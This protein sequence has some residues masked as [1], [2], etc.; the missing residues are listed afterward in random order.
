[1][2]G[3][4]S[5]E[6]PEVNRTPTGSP[7]LD[8]MSKRIG[9]GNTALSRKEALVSHLLPPAAHPARQLF[10][11]T[12]LVAVTLGERPVPVDIWRMRRDALAFFAGCPA[13]RRIAYIRLNAS[14]DELELVTFGRRGGWKREWR[15]GPAGR[16]VR[17]A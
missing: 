7:S 13:A 12:D 10:E 4:G 15:F 16:K 8:T 14:T 17:L 5:T 9:P 1:M 11:V 2:T 6:A 3:K